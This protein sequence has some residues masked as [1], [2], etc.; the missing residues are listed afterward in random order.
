MQEFEEY[1][2]QICDYHR[3]TTNDS[4]WHWKYIPEETKVEISVMIY[5]Y[6]LYA[7][8][9]RVGTDSPLFE[10][11]SHVKYLPSLF[12]TVTVYYS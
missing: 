6:C 5:T 11:L 2:F 1:E 10:S 9:Q 8:T 4:V 12:F 3:I 7:G